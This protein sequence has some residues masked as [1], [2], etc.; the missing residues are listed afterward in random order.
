MNAFQKKSELNELRNLFHNKMRIKV[1]AEAVKKQEFVGN[2]W[3]G[4]W[5]PYRPRFPSTQC[6]HDYNMIAP[7]PPRQPINDQKL[8]IKHDKHLQC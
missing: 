6:D 2:V 1:A 7:T 5:S 3:N 8:S 4:T